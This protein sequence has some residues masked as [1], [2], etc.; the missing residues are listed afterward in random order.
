MAAD[1]LK[2]PVKSAKPGAAEGNRVAGALDFTHPPSLIS[3]QFSYDPRGRNIRWADHP[4]AGSHGRGERE[5]VDVVIDRRRNGARRREGHGAAG[6]N[7]RSTG[8]GL[9]TERRIKQDE[10]RRGDRRDRVGE[11]S[12]GAAENGEPRFGSKIERGREAET[13]LIGIERL[14]RWRRHRMGREPELAVTDRILGPTDGAAEHSVHYI[15]LLDPVECRDE[16][17]R[18]VVGRA[19]E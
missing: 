15:A 1:P 19:A 14:R 10:V 13:V 9:N 12:P 7:D 11:R 17:R 4:A 2:K 8:R 5:R 18:F 6:V 3:H 16:S